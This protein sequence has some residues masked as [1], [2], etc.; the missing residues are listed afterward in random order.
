MCGGGG[1]IRYIHE[2]DHQTFEVVTARRIPPHVTDAEALIKYPGA[3]LAVEPCACQM[4]MLQQQRIDRLTN[5][6]GVAGDA[7][8][9]SLEDFK[10]QQDVYRAAR[11]VLTGEWRG[12]LVSGPTGTGKTTWARLVYQTLVEDGIAAVWQNFMT[13]QDK[14]RATYDDDYEGPSV[15]H[16]IAPLLTADALV[17]DDLGSPTR[18]LQPHKTAVYAEDVIKLLYRIFDARLAGQK[19]T[20]ITTNLGKQ[21]LYA[22]FGEQVTSRILGLCHGVT[23][24]GIDY[25]TG[26]R[27]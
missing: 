7:V 2:V 12:A 27:R 26:E 11:F 18:A 15:E 1:W 17:L 5:Q 10:A 14:L 6:P 21:D 25:R 19:L 8:Q 13:L 3:N 23:M 20:I 16:L 9:F 24:R 22:Q 4:A